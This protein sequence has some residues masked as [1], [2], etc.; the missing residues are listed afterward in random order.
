MLDKLEQVF[1]VDNNGQIYVQ[2]RTGVA[3]VQVRGLAKRGCSWSV[4][5]CKIEH[6]EL[7]CNMCEGGFVAEEADCS[8][9][10]TAHPGTHCGSRFG[11]VGFRAAPH[12]FTA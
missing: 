12:V 1:C 2:G 5:C 9:A 10:W 7:I 6:L 8:A 4:G 3:T 11:S